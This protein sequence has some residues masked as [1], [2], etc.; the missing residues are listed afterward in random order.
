[1][2]RGRYRGPGQALVQPRSDDVSFHG[3]GGPHVA[4]A[5]VQVSERATPAPEA[6][7]AP[8]RRGVA[9]MTLPPLQDQAPLILACLGPRPTFSSQVDYHAVLAEFFAFVRN[10]RK[11]QPLTQGFARDFED[12]ARLE[13]QLRQLHFRFELQRDL[14]RAAVVLSAPEADADAAGSPA[15]P[16]ATSGAAEL[17]RLAGVP[18]VLEGDQI[19]VGPAECLRLMLQMSS[20]FGSQSYTYVF[21]L[22]RVALWLVSHGAVVPDVLPLRQA[23]AGCAEFAVVFLPFATSAPAAGALAQLRAAF[24]AAAD[25]ACVA[26]GGVPQPPGP[27]TAQAVCVMLTRAV[28]ALGFRHAKWGKRPP[29]ISLAFWEGQAYEAMALEERSVAAGVRRWVGVLQLLKLDLA[30]SV[31]VK[32]AGSS[33]G[34]DQEAAGPGPYLLSIRLQA[35]G[36]HAGPPLPPLEADGSTT[37]R[38]TADP[39]EPLPLSAFYAAHR[40]HQP[41]LLQFL[42]SLSAYL[43]GVQ[44]LLTHDALTLEGPVFERFITETSATLSS[45]GCELTMPRHLRRLLKP[46]LVIAATAAAREEGA[47]TS[48][49]SFLKMAE[50]LRYEWKV[51]LGDGEMVSLAEFHALVARGR[52]LVHFRDAFVML[53]AKEV[54][55]ILERAQQP[56]D[57]S[58]L[59]AMDLLR[60]SMLEA[61]SELRFSGY[62][63]ELLRSLTGRAGA[64]DAPGPDAPPAGLAAALRP[65]QLQGFQWLAAHAANGMGCVL[66]DDMGLGK[67]LQAIALLLHLKGTRSPW[68]AALVVVPSSLM[69]NWR[70]E[71]QRFAPTLRVM[72]YHGADRGAALKKLLEAGGSRGCVTPAGDR[73]AA[74]RQRVA[75]APV[76][77]VLTSYGTL[78]AE[79]KSFVGDQG[80]S[81]VIV[82]EAQTIKNPNAQVLCVVGRAM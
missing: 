40:E 36:G 55:A 41:K 79:A 71:M 77:V 66:A 46:R 80:W 6:D 10:E 58:K 57:V 17:L 52:R 3:G 14:R 11:L 19:R 47:G 31:F 65:Y 45:L 81:C 23:D 32:A 27:G 63:A 76:D 25:G 37:A 42:S 28:R 5:Y 20:P 50:L 1:M 39:A 16:S 51:A 7:A 56:P 13:R 78:K 9:R 34:D 8:A 29:A 75:A 67:T 48:Y 4:I 69:Y 21:H 59:Q 38:A 72:L 12:G 61:Q 2:G 35:K 64:R 44:R 24:P 82:D 49:Q 22:S 60:A 30:V 74:K 43:P 15:L 18:A 62:A 33:P 54:Q 26:L 73:P 53:D 68:T 70:R